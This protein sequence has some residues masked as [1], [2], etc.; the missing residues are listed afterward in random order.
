MKR[1][2]RLTLPPL[3]SEQRKFV[4]DQHRIVVAAC[5]TKTGKTFGL[6]EWIILQAWNRE[7][8]LS[9][10]TAPTLRQCRIAFNTIERWLPPDR[11]RAH[12]SDANMGFDLIKSDGSVYSRIQMRSAENP[13][14]LRGDGVHACVIDEAGYWSQPSFV[15][16]WTTLTQ[17]RGK[18]RIISTPKGRNWFYDEWQKGWHLNPRR[19]ENSE[20]ASYKLPTHTN[21]WVPRESL[22]EAQ[23]NLPENV[24][25]Q[26]YMA[27][28]LDD[29]AGVFRNIIGC[30]RTIILERP[31]RGA[32]YAMGIDWAKH[33]DYTVFLV[34]DLDTKQVV[35]I[36]RHNDIDWNINI[37]RAIKC[38]RTWN[39][40]FVLMDSTGVGDVPFDLM[41]A[42]Y[43]LV[44]G[45]NIYNNEQKTALIQ[46]MQ[47]ALEKGAIY[48][49]KPDIQTSNRNAQMADALQKEL[50]MYSYTMTPSQKMKFSAPE[51]YYDDM[52]IALALANWKLEEPPL[53]YR[54]RS[55]QGL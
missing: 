11:A 8:S 16:V 3:H 22:V 40:A 17:T 51:G 49:P 37:M 53:I 34:V 31:I 12:R 36:E 23:R 30:Q 33:N 9:W 46:K 15:S 25:R 21:P 13:D 45:F 52:V 55:V 43:P 19:D 5:G 38:A 2:V 4:E 44:E 18:L 32:K 41:A 27:E 54:A 47:V 24:F 42:S 28:F 6:C 50:E 26:E 20:Y 10:W 35:Y 1:S 48:L 39:N 7:Q 29:S 14:S